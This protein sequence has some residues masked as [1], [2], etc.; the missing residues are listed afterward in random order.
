MLSLADCL[1]IPFPASSHYLSARRLIVSSCPP[2]C[3]GFNILFLLPHLFDSASRRL[4]R[5]AL[6]ALAVPASI[7]ELHLLWTLRSG[8][9]TEGASMSLHHF[10]YETLVSVLMIYHFHNITKS[11]KYFNNELL[12]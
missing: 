9:P 6:E 1:I 7:E 10:E 2:S 4:F 3:L 11:F 12:D 8:S 5:G